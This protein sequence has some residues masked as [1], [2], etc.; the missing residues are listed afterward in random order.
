ML[1]HFFKGR[2]TARVS[3]G[4]VAAL[5]GL[6]PASGAQSDPPTTRAGESSSPAPIDEITRQAKPL[7]IPTRDGIEAP[8]ATPRGPESRIDPAK[9]ESASRGNGS[10]TLGIS[11]GV[12]AALAV[13]CATW[14][15]LRHRRGRRSARRVRPLGHRGISDSR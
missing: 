8:G 10:P 9:P 6:A 12:A 14:W 5:L 13:G 2:L 11:V 1:D 4:A 7:P 15:V 3:A